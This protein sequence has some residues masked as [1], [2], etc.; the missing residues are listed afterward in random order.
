LVIFRFAHHLIPRHAQ[1]PH[2]APKTT[3]SSRGAT[4]ADLPVRAYC[5]VATSSGKP[6][7]RKPRIIV[8]SCKAVNCG[9]LYGSRPRMRAT[10]FISGVSLT[11]WASSVL[12][13]LFRLLDQAR[14]RASDE[15]TRL[16]DSASPPFEAG[17]ASSTWP[18]S[19]W[20]L[21][22][23]I[24]AKPSRGLKLQRPFD[25]GDTWSRLTD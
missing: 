25:I 2:P 16:Q 14:P 18:R 12:A 17:I 1:R 6:A 8:R 20:H 10:E 15:H 11:I 5:W 3:A 13:S 23:F 7:L 4:A 24:Y 22:K 9:F 19:R 21:P